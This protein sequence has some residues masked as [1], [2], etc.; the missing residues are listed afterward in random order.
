[1]EGSP[2]SHCYHDLEL[3]QALDQSVLIGQRVVKCMDHDRRPKAIP[4]GH[5]QRYFLEIIEN[6]KSHERHLQLSGLHGNVTSGS[7]SIISRAQ[8]RPMNHE[9]SAFALNE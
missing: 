2:L 6:G 5:C 8:I 3:A 4:I 9:D 7:L 1:Q